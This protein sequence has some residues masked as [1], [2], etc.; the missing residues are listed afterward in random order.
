M[1]CVIYSSV[2]SPFCKC[3][4]GSV[5]FRVS[6]LWQWLRVQYISVFRTFILYLIKGYAEELIEDFHT[7]DSLL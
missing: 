5:L 2:L 3:L 7:L 6:A 1:N 4:S